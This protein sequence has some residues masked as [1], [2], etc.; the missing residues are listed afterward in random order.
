[1]DWNSRLVFP[2]SAIVGQ[3]RLKRALLANVVSPAVGGVLIRG[4]KG[5]A[6]STAVRAL[7]SIMPKV[8]V[9]V[10]CPFGCAPGGPRCSWC[11]G[12]NGSARVESRQVRMVDLPVGVTEDRVVG[13]LDF[14]HAMRTG[15]VRLDPGLL[16]RANRG[17]LYV[18]EVNLLDAGVAALVLDAS[19]SGWNRVEREGVSF[20]H[21]SRFV[22][23]GSMNPEEGLPGPQLVDRFGLCV[24]VVGLDDVDQRVTL[25]RRILEFE[26]DP[27]SFAT[28]WEPAQEALRKRID[29]ARQAI[30]S[31]KISDALLGRIGCVSRDA[32][33][34]GHRAELT[35]RHA[36]LALAA[37][38]QAAEVDSCHV[39]EAAE[40]ALA[41]RLRLMPPHQSPPPMPDQGRSQQ[42]QGQS[43]PP[44]PA[45]IPPPQCDP[46]ECDPG[47]TPPQQS[48]GG[49]APERVFGI[50][51]SFSVCRIVPPKDRLA[52]NSDGR[53]AKTR[54]QSRAGRYVSSRLPRGTGDIAFDATLRAAAPHQASR[55]K[56][57][58]ALALRREDLREKA[59]ER[60]TS[61]L[62]ILAVDASGSMGAMQRMEE[63]KGAVLSLLQDAYLKRDKVGLIAFRGQEAEELLPPTRS[64]DLARRLL[65][66]LPTG[67]RTPLAAG[68]AQ[69]YEVARRQLLRDPC[70]IP[71]LVI[72]TDGRANAS[73]NNEDPLAETA[74][75]ASGI[76]LDMRL[77]PI[78]VDVEQDGMVNLGLAR[79]L[80]GQMN[81]HYFR[82]AD[83][84]ADQLASFI[85]GRGAEILSVID[86]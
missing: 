22:L 21:P 38:D 56:N 17:V 39:D 33:A 42:D 59:R 66:E 77:H 45:D 25:L 47:D 60:K 81:A 4:H 61:T 12:H 78:V 75:L 46:R 7:A 55:D 43:P 16:G 18:D 84:R 82:M 80:A 57:G 24:D 40:M 36:A 51:E 48:S 44:Q 2:F 58:L 53:R 83:L 69:A 23:V 28:R 35:M 64:I 30:Q 9:V 19:A 26:A 73:Q 11:M 37:L 50:G 5:A 8:E 29:Q 79:R 67:G 14:E 74:R 86:R 10:G 68:L 85:R 15:G 65:A 3:K 49:P 76:G 63:A 34:A 6:K 1:M 62:I 31:M 27:T 20:M 72:V 54:T 32:G 71:M 52:R 13:S 70:A 41:H